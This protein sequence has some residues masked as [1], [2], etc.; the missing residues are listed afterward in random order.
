MS[1]RHTSCCF[2][3]LLRAPGLKLSAEMFKLTVYGASSVLEIFLKNAVCE[4]E[5]FKRN[6]VHFRH[7]VYFNGVTIEELFV[8]MVLVLMLMMS[9]TSFLKMQVVYP[10]VIQNTVCMGQNFLE[11]LKLK[12]KKEILLL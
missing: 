3:V 11:V 4:G 10:Y 2:S 12:G 8:S 1:T 5:I 6:A 9:T 7:A